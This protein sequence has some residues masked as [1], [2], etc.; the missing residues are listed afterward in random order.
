MADKESFMRQCETRLTTLFKDIEQNYDIMHGTS[1]TD[2]LADNLDEVRSIGSGGRSVISSERFGDRHDGWETNSGRWELRE[3]GGTLKGELAVQPYDESSEHVPETSALEEP[4]EK[5][6]S[7]KG[8]DTPEAFPEEDEW[9][10]LPWQAVS[11]DTALDQLGSRLRATD[12]V[13]CRK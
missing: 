11:V 3:K 1:R 5:G 10:S 7:E 13:Y 8:E 2:D 12:N 9:K 4:P 6:S